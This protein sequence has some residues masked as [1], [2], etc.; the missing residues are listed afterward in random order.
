MATF[1]ANYVRDVSVQVYRLRLGEKDADAMIQE[2][3]EKYFRNAAGS[4]DTITRCYLDVLMEVAEVEVEKPA[5][6]A[7]KPPGV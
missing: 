7:G 1:P 2:K 6:D 4:L 3:G 5:N